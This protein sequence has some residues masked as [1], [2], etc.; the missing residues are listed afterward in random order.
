MLRAFAQW[1]ALAQLEALRCEHIISEVAIATLREQLEQAGKRLQLR[2]EADEEL[3]AARVRPSHLRQYAC[4]EA[5]T[6]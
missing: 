1:R 2:I 4:I 6:S 3:A 5:T